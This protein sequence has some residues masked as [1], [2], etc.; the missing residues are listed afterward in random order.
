LSCVFSIFPEYVC[1]LH[2]KTFHN[3]KL[4]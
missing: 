3:V 4:R 1:A 2:S